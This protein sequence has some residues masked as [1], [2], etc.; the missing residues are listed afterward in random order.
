MQCAEKAPTAILDVMMADIRR[1]VFEDMLFRE[2]TIQV[3]HPAR[4]LPVVSSRR[5]A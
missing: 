5:A 3:L 4:R 1:S 2:Q